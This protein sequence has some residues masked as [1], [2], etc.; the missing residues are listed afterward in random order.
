MLAA[1]ISVACVLI[2]ALLGLL[3]FISREIMRL[4]REV[5][6]LNQG[7]TEGAQRLILQLGARV[8]LL[9]DVAEQYGERLHRNGIRL[10]LLRAQT[11][12]PIPLAVWGPSGST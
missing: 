4:T 2:A 10:E 7:A 1:G 8:D 12:P 6:L 11:S 3:G 5:A 9:E